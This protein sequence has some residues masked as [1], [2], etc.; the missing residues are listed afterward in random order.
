MLEEINRYGRVRSISKG[1]VLIAPGDSIVF[2]PIVQSG[3]LR[4]IRQNDDGREIFL[5]H[6]YPGQACA[7]AINCCQGKKISNVKAIAEEESNILQIAANQVEEWH[8][9]AEWRTFITLTYS[10]RFNEL[11]DVI[12][13]IAFNNMDKQVLHYLTERAH[14]TGSNK[15]YLTHQEIAD[16]LH[17]QREAIS[18]LLRTMEQKKILKL[19]RNIIEL[20]TV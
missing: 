9:Y 3:T 15:L 6:L 17:T 2:I 16:E 12:D 14:A 5:Y 1:S 20:L 4:I 13:L 18:R 8:K 10:Q 19:G 7:M 11:L